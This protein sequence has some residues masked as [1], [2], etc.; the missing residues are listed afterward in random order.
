MSVCAGDT[1]DMQAQHF[2]GLP[3]YRPALLGISTLPPN[4]F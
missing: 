1:S 3:F 4:T 2:W